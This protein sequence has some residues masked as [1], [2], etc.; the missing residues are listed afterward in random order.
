MANEIQ[1]AGLQD[2]RLQETLNREVLLALADRNMLVNHPARQHRRVGKPH[3]H[4]SRRCEPPSNGRPLLEAV[5][6]N[7]IGQ[8]YRQLGNV[9]EPRVLGSRLRDVRWNDDDEPNCRARRWLRFRQGKYRSRP[10]VGPV[11]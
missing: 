9:S 1:Y 7:G 4:R 11:L 3:K 2:L 8:H 5:P 6:G 10:H